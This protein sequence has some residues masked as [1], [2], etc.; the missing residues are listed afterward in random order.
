[1]TRDLL[2]I[3]DLRQAARKRLP[4][5]VFDTIDGGAGSEEALRRNRAAFCA[6]AIVTRVLQAVGEPLCALDLS[7]SPSAL[8]LIVGPTGLSGL[9]W[10]QGE[11]AMA[12]AAAS[13]GIVYILS[14]ISSVDLEAVAEATPAPKWFQL[15]LFE[16]RDLMASLM[17]RAAAAG[18]AALVVTVDTPVVGRR[19][20]DLRSGLAMPPRVTPAF[21]ASMLAHP[22]WSRPYLLGYRP[23]PA[24]IEAGLSRSGY[25]G[26]PRFHA[27]ASWKDIA[28]IR[29]AWPGKLVVKGLMAACD[30]EAAAGYGA[31]AVILSNH[32]GR[33]LDAACST[34]AALRALG[35]SPLEI[36]LDGGVRSGSDILKALALGAR[37]VAVGRAPLYGLAAGGEGLASRAIAILADE[38]REAMILAG[39]PTVADA[40]Q[41]QLIWEAQ[42]DRSAGP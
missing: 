11:L 42:G 32:G 17:Q 31:D 36:Y 8:P 10:P 18:Y 22:G 7:G 26:L 41:C 1:M 40:S 4:R 37:A 16:D 39:C 33:Q 35:P 5:A 9:Y 24:N 29:K 12:R 14:C 38:L 25:R 19:L 27:S 15:Y 30:L 3:E 6:A 34:L 13:H 21:A 20:R 23:S 28:A 2:T